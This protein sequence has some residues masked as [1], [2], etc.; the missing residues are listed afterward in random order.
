MV[1][2]GKQNG[3]HQGDPISE[4]KDWRRSEDGKQPAALFSLGGLWGP[5]GGEERL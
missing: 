5:S 3:L 1:P 4:G 2:V